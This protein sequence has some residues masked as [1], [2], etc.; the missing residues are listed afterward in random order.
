MQS[1]KRTS[2]MSQRSSTGK[3]PRLVASTAVVD[4]REIPACWERPFPVNG[5]GVMVFNTDR[6]G[7]PFYVSI[8]SQDGVYWMAL[9]VGIGYAAFLRQGQDDVAPTE[10]KR[11]EGAEYGVENGKQTYWYSYDRDNLVLKY[12]KGYRM[13]ETTM[14]VVDF[15]EGQ[16]NPEEV[17]KDMYPYFN[18]EGQRFV[19]QYDEKSNMTIYSSGIQVTEP[20]VEFDKQPLICN[21]PPKVMD[22]SKVTLFDLD[23][24]EFVFS[25]SLPSACKELYSNIKGCVLDYSENVEGEK[26]LL[27]DAIRY[28]IYNGILRDKLAEKVGELSDDKDGTYLRVT[29]GS[30]LGKSPGIPYVLEIWPAGH[31]SPVH[32]HGNANAVIKVLYGSLD[33][34]IYNKQTGREVPEPI[35]T[36]PISKND[37]VWIDRNWYQTHK[38]KNNGTEY[39]A[40]IQ[41]YNYA[42]SDTTYWPYFDFISDDQT[43]DEFFP[44]SDFGFVEMRTQVMAEYTEYVQGIRKAINPIAV[45]Y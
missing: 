28:S 10:L 42:A 4:Q 27:T 34:S 3:K 44:S 30:S 15:L 26:V 8:E 32:N 9:H 17:R 35:S 2:N 43:I 18:A 13:E 12:G 22:S 38:L 31:F 45:P 29:L 21:I 14:M 16:D 36:V 23:R 11:V 1:S 24:G 39:C 40:T 41:C 20:L 19:R 25:A 37:V 33:V 5:Q 7:L 6:K